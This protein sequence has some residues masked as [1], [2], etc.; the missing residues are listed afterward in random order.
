MVFENIFGP[1][2]EN[3]NIHPM[4]NPEYSND[5]INNQGKQYKLYPA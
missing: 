5:I 3:H 2:E 1:P 4:T